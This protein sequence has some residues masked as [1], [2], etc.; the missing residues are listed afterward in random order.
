MVTIKKLCDDIGGLR[1]ESPGVF[2]KSALVEQM[3]FNWDEPDR[4]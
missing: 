3:S 1:Q 2:K 4:A